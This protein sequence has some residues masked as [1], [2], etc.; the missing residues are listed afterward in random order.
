MI[1]HPMPY[2]I[3]PGTMADWAKEEN[4]LAQQTEKDARRA[5]LTVAKEAAQKRKRAAEITQAKET[6]AYCSSQ[7]ERLYQV[8]TGYKNA[9]HYAQKQVDYDEQANRYGAVVTQKQLDRH[10]KERDK[11]LSKVVTAETAIYRLEAQL[12]KA[13]NIL[14]APD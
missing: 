11:L 7:L 10:I 6:V 3:T 8:I 13:E 1:Y 4:R 12:R 14:T 9:L 2:V 5:A